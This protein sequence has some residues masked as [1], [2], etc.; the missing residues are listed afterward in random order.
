MTYDGVVLAGGEGR[1]LGGVVKPAI[2]IAGRRLL[3][4]ALDALAGAH[5]A[6]AVGAALPTSRPVVWTCEEPTGGG[7]V[8]ALAAA[9]PL[10]HSPYVV[11]LAADLPFITAGGVA[12]LL[13]VRRNAAAVIAVDGEGHDQPL[14][15][16]YDTARLRAAMPDEPQGASMR[17]VLR[18]LDVDGVITRIDLGGDP[19]ATW[20]CDTAADLNRAEELA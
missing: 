9:L 3:D 7:P 17:S 20:D 16:L 4:I 6:V 1:R 5:T 10:L 11:V 8:A 12:Q 14:L 13:R 2:T 15:A 18:R 19:P